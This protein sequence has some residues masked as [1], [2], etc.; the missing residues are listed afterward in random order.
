[1]MDYKAYFEKFV[2][3]CYKRFDEEDERR[4]SFQAMNDNYQKTQ[5]KLSEIIEVL[6]KPIKCNPIDFIDNVQFMDL[7]GISQKTAQT[8]RDTGII[9]FSQVGN[10]IYYRIADIQD[11]LDKNLRKSTNQQSI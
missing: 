6:N 3:D 10:K 8:W 11:L 2:T 1:M 7:M 4:Q 5:Q 9:S